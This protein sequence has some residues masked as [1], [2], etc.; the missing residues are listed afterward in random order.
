MKDEIYYGRIK[1]LSFVLLDFLLL[2]TSN[3]IAFQVYIF[4]YKPE[5][6]YTLNKH[7]FVVI[8]MAVIDFFITAVFNTLERVLRRRK[9]KELYEGIKHVGYSYITLAVILFLFRKSTDYSRLTITLA[10]LIYFVLFIGV[11][12]IWKYILKK[13]IQRPARK[14]VLLMTMDGFLNEGIQRLQEQDFDVRY[15]YL[16]KNSKVD[17]VEEIPV[18]KKWEKAASAICWDLIDRVYIYGLDHQMVPQYMINACRDMG[19]KIHLVDFTYRII[20]IKTIGH[21]D[22]G[23]GILSTLEEKRDIPFSIRRVYWITETEAE[24]HRGYHAHKLN[25]QL[26]FCPYGV[27]DLILDDGTTRNTVTLDRPDKCLL[28]MPGIW[29][30]MVWKK[31]GS[32]LCVIASGYYDPKEY[33]RNY[34]EFLE[35]SRKYR[36]GSDKVNL[37]KSS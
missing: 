37:N 33:I 5:N 8:I 34:D 32:V 18:I 22:P 15:I 36:A 31:S 2:L 24:F 20:N 35:Y 26:L 23:Y 17:I 21:D 14:T 19:L 16:L 7:I 25:C 4:Q 6:E 10:Y 30:E 11:H 12:I 1:Y 13:F 9:K 27:I 29:R 28:L 3:Y